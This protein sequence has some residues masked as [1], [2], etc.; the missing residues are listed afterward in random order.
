MEKY[1]VQIPEDVSQMLNDLSGEWVT[2]QQTLIDADA[3]LKKHKVRVLSALYVLNCFMKYQYEF[4]V[5]SMIRN[6]NYRR[7]YESSWF[8]TPHIKWSCYN[9]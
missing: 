7:I 3:M 9:K 1:E 2:F 5:A 8:V 4:A 6:W